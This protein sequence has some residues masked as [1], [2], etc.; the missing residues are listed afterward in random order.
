[1]PD[2]VDNVIPRP[3]QAVYDISPWIDEQIW[4]HRLWDGQTPWLLFL[5]F[6]TVAEACYR[7]NRLL[8]SAELEKLITFKPYKRMFLRN[9]LF[10]SEFLSKVD[11]NGRDSN[12]AWKEWLEWM[13]NEAKGVP[14]SDFSYL[15]AR[16][17][18]FRNFAALVA[19]VRS[20]AVESQTNRRWTSRFVFPFGMHGLYEDLAI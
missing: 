10:N 16:F 15:K 7:E 14:S 5:E 4:G 17:Q 12:S 19:T 18:S 3:P 8:D 11:Q 9:I 2:I 13:T 1:M 20:S 6:L